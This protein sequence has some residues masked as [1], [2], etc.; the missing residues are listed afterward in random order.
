MAKVI[1][2]ERLRER[3]FSIVRGNPSLMSNS[4]PAEIGTSWR[5]GQ[6]LVWHVE[7]LFES[8]SRDVWRECGKSWGVRDLEKA[9][10]LYLR[11]PKLEMLSERCAGR[12]ALT[13]DELL[14][15]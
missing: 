8:L 14:D 6:E 3:I 15:F 5:I 13:L 1:E 2:A 9:F 11:Y 4:I 12:N 7:E 10:K